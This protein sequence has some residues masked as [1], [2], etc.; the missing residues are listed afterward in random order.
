MH[1]R[2]TSE[3][4]KEIWSDESKYKLW[5]DIELAVCEAHA[6]YGNLDKKIPPEIEKCKWMCVG[7]KNSIERINEIEK[8]TKHDVLAFLT[9]LSQM[10][11]P[12][13][14]YIHMG[15][16]SQDLLDTCTAIQTYNSIK[17]ILN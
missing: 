6:K 9:Y 1:N 16:T 15:M 12:S 17:I 8:K 10:I 14:K 11:G 7:A 4:I 13:A 5:F 2:Y 3:K